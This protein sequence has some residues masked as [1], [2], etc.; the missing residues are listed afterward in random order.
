MDLIEARAL[1]V[2]LDG[3]GV[4]AFEKRLGEAVQDLEILEGAC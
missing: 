1:E 3:V 4:P 2:V